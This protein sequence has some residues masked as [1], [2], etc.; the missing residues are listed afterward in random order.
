MN[1]KRNFKP[2]PHALQEPEPQLPNFD[3]FSTRCRD[4]RFPSI[5]CVETWTRDFWIEFCQNGDAPINRD[6]I[7]LA[8]FSTHKLTTTYSFV[9]RLNRLVHLTFRFPTW[10]CLKWNGETY[11]FVKADDEMGSDPSNLNVSMSVKYQFVFNKDGV[12]ASSNFDADF[13]ALLF[14]IHYN[15]DLDS[16]SIDNSRSSFQ[17]AKEGYDDEG[18]WVD[19]FA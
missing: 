4:F 18:H 14:I 1:L 13:G 19:G 6:E 3:P 11:F 5:V 16:F 15:I 12:K 17:I 8:N 9:E 10:A 7:P 2:S